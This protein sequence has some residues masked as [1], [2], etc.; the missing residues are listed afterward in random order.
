[1]SQAQKVLKEAGKF[2]VLDT[3]GNNSKVVSTPVSRTLYANDSGK[4]WTLGNT[5]ADITMTLPDVA[6][7]G[8]GWYGK[9]VVGTTPTNGDYIITENTASDTNLIHGGFVTSAI[10]SAGST[11]ATEGTGTTLIN[12][13][14]NISLKGDFVDLVTDGTSWYIANSLIQTNNAVVLA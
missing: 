13:K 4:I 2:N 7:A 10:S 9:F 12:F 1:M 5:S 11:P 6:S 14:G 3:S 8:S